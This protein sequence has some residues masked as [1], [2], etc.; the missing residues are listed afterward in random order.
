MQNDTQFVV[1]KLNNSSIHIFIWKI[2][3]NISSMTSK[4]MCTYVNVLFSATVM[5][6]HK[7][8]KFS[9]NSFWDNEGVTHRKFY[10]SERLPFCSIFQSSVEKCLFWLLLFLGCLSL[11]LFHFSFMFTRYKNIAKDYLSFCFLN[12][13]EFFCFEDVFCNQLCILE[14]FLDHPIT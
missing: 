1:C 2:V 13:H 3:P 6:Q 11:K 8:S 4:R 12:I 14:A 9:I 7:Q 5:I 10:K